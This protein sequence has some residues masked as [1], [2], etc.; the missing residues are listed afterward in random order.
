[1]KFVILN[2]PDT[3][4]LVCIY[5]GFIIVPSGQII[6]D[7]SDYG[8]VKPITS[9]YSNDNIEVIITRKNK[10]F[11]YF[12]LE[13]EGFAFPYLGNNLISWDYKQIGIDDYDLFYGLDFL[14]SFRLKLFNQEKV[15][16]IFDYL[17]KTTRLIVS[18]CD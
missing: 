14:K 1:V 12:P 18:D 8:W 2:K 4:T 16:I 13:Y 15:I 9:L 11:E 6:T 17:T 5:T 7:N 3:D 10:E